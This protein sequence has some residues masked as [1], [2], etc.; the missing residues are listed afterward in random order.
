M[1]RV[2][3]IKALKSAKISRYITFAIF[4]GFKTTAKLGVLKLYPMNNFS[5]KKILFLMQPFLHIYTTLEKCMLKTFQ[6][7]SY[8]IYVSNN[9]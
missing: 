3:Q 5:C 6:Q 2:Y 4:T 9:V 7:F 1:G 8:I